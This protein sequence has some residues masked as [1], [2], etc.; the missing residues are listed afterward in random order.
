[1]KFLTT[2]R[3]L[4]AAAAFL[5]ALCAAPGAQAFTIEG[6][7]GSGS[8]QGFMDLDKPAAPPDRLGPRRAST[9][10]MARRTIQAGQHDVPVRI[11]SA[12]SISATTPITCSTPTPAKGADTHR[13]RVRKAASAFCASGEAS[14]VLK[15][16]T[17]SSMRATI[18]STE[19]RINRR[20]ST[21]LS[22]GKAAISFAVASARASS[23]AAGTTALTMP[24]SRACSAAKACP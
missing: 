9:A 15:A 5:A 10:K 7:G 19:P 17:S 18:S 8:G 3:A 12:H 20:A 16:S 2:S 24:A 11:S 23:S 22:V 1:M 6:S 21:T 13:F 4:I 14:R